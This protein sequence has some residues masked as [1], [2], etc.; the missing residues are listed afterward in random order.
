MADVYL[1][2]ALKKDKG[3]DEMASEELEA[4]WR[5]ERKEREE[6]YGTGETEIK[7]KV[8]IQQIPSAA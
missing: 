4:M 2:N 6:Q 7:G 3:K 5:E 8:T 1:A